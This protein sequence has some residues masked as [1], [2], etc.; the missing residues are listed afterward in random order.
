MPET[1][2]VAAEAMA[3]RFEVA[4]HGAPEAILRAAAEEALAE[5]TRLEGMLSLYQP[6]SEIAHINTRGDREPVRVSPE[7]FSLLEH[8]AALGEQTEGCFDITLAPLMRCWRFMNDSG[9]AP[10]DAALA[11]ARALCGWPQLRLDPEHTTVQLATNGAMLDLGSVGKGYALEQA[12][13]LLQENEFENFLIHGGTSTVCARGVQAD[14][15][16]WRIAVEHPDADQPPLSIVDLQN[17]S[18]SVSGIGGKSFID[19]AGVEQGHVI[20]P[21]T[22]RPTQAARVAAVV[23]SSATVSDAWATALLVVPN[24]DLPAGIRRA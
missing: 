6:T 19:D 2:T 16:P 18:L 17:E 7:V 21:R 22:G 4:L 12:A 1:V 11:A 10:S 3:T 9:A 14:G 23:C 20:D 15:E 5:I 13:T 24:L 8:C